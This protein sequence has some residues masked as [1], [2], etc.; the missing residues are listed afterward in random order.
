MVGAFFAVLLLTSL[1]K[2]ELVHSIVVPNLLKFIF[3]Y[4][5]QCLKIIFSKL[6]FSMQNYGFLK[7]MCD[8]NVSL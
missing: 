1:D 2:T 4:T 8:E 5:I 3:T 7:Q 6:Y